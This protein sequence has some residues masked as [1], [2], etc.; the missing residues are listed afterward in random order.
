MIQD[1]KAGIQSGDVIMRS[2]RDFTSYRIRELS[3][4]DK[5]YSHAGIAL[6]TDSNVLI[7]HITPPD[8]DEPKSDTVMRLETLDQFANPAR[9]FGFGIVRYQLSKGETDSAMYYLDSLKKSKTTFDYR[10]DLLDG[11]KMYCSEM[12][13]NTMRYATSNRISLE[14]KYFTKLQA[15]KAARYFHST[16]EE[17]NK[18]AYISIDNLQLNPHCAIIYNYLFLK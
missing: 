13:D 14:R 18:R 11:K 4:K 1:A 2:G 8:L 12:V 16:M 9:C 7:Y 15:K 10:F 6:V 5:T 17:V 3:D